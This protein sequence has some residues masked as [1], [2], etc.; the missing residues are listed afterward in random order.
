M[1][2]WHNSAAG[3][4]SATSTSKIDSGINMKDK[5]EIT[6]LYNNF[7]SSKTS[8]ESLRNLYDQAITDEEARLADFF[9][10]TFDA[11][12][13]IPTRPCKPD[14]PHSWWGPMPKFGDA[15]LAANAVPWST[16]VTNNAGTANTIAYPVS[17]AGRSATAA[18][19][20]TSK[21]YL[22]LDSQVAAAGTTATLKS[23]G[24][25]FGRLGQGDA[26][27]PANASPFAW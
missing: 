1:M 7:N 15:N 8:Y 25:A 21:G 2:Q 9:K 26:S 22:H 17:D 12:I 11:P 4:Y 16:V 3:V 23:T 20:A 27:M 24:K 6:T 19:W 14:T 13:A 18:S 10:A 5:A